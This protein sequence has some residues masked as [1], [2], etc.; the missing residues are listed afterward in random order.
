MY[1]GGQNES[2]SGNAPEATLSEAFDSSFGRRL[3]LMSKDQETMNGWSLTRVYRINGKLVIGDDVDDAIKAYRQ[4]CMNDPVTIES[5]ELVFCGA[6]NMDCD[7]V[8]ADDRRKAAE[9][10]A[11]LTEENEKLQAK[12][13]QLESDNKELVEEMFKMRSQMQIPTCMPENPMLGDVS[14]EYQ[15]PDDMSEMNVNEWSRKALEKALERNGG[16]RKRAAKELGI[17]DRT[18][19]RRLKQYGLNK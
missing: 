7:A 19:Y 15:E 8:I 2:G 11:M 16:D 12:C 4:W 3:C 6:G 17:S 5:V 10:I 18:M 1:D 14:D 13:A 9:T